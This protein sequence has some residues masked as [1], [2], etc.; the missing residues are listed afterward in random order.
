MDGLPDAQLL[1]RAPNLSIEGAVPDSSYGSLSALHRRIYL[2]PMT[3][4]CMRVHLLS[5]HVQALVTTHYPLLQSDTEVQML[6][7]ILNDSLT[8]NDEACMRLKAQYDAFSY[9]WLTDM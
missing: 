6:V 1:R 3:T 8:E 7:A 2:L 4:K 9:L 5:N